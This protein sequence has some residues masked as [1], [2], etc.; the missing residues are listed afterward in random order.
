MNS[1]HE[2]DNESTES[3]KHCESILL[4]LIDGILLEESLE[5]IWSV[6]SKMVNLDDIYDVESLNSFV[7]REQL[8]A[9]QPKLKYS[10]V[11]QTSVVGCPIC[12][13][14]VAGKRFAPHLEKCMNG[15]KRG[16]RKYSEVFDM[17]EIEQI[18]I[19]KPKKVEPNDPYPNSLIIRIKI[20]NGE[21]SGNTVRMGA[22]MEEFEQKQIHNT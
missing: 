17:N 11:T 7:R 16:A 1:V 13:E 14:L 19:S 9:E 10:S 22:S 5:A 20:R 21:P 8:M 18:K 4:L 6:K 3:S 15:G 12:K 2:Y